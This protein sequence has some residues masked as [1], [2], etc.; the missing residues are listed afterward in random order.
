MVLELVSGPPFLA[1]LIPLTAPNAMSAYNGIDLTTPLAN[2]RFKLCVSPDQLDCF[3]SFSVTHMDGTVEKPIGYPTFSFHKGSVSG[4]LMELTFD[5]FITTPAQWDIKKLV[6]FD[7]PV[8]V[9]YADMVGMSQVDPTDTFAMTLRTSWL[10]P[11]DVAGFARNS[12]VTE[13]LIPGGRR[14]V[15]SG[16]QAVTEIFNL[17]HQSWYGDLANP[18][19][20]ARAADRDYPE[21]Y[22]RIDHINPVPN[23]SAFN[24]GCS[25][26]GYTITSSNAS[27][28]GMPTMLN[29]DTLSYNVYAPHF[30][31]DGI[32]VTEG[33]FEATIPVAWLDCKWPGNTLSKAAK[34]EISVIDE[35]GVRQVAS[36]TALVK[37]GKLDIKIAGFHYS[38]PIIQIRPAPNEQAIATPTPSATLAQTS[39]AKPITITCVKG[40]SVKKVVAVKPVCP[41]GYLKK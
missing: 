24:T 8:L 39:A 16:Q 22:W 21:M 7:F 14:R 29:A 9:I 2:E 34:I 4:P 36:S 3:E 30:K 17:E 23:G 37:N 32:S 38:A 28:A 20:P 10:N 11:L 41:K 5:V 33:F 15:F 26:A 19:A 13:T 27:S 31:M 18:S 40:K 25:Q 12:S 35:K 6:G 1:P